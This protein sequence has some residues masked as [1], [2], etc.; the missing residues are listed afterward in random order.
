[1]YIFK[2]MNRIMGRA[3]AE[4]YL[5]RL[6]NNFKFIK[7]TVGKKKIMAAI[8]ADAYG[9]GA[10]EVAKTLQELGV[11]MFGVASIE[12]GIELRLSGIRTKIVILSPVMDEQVEECIEY[13]LIPTISELAFFERLNKKLMHYRKPLL[14]HIEVDTGM[15]RTGFPYDKTIDALKRILSSPYIKIEGIFS[16]FP[17]AD[18]DGA[19]SREQIKKFS[20]LIAQLDSMKIRPKFVHLANSSGIFRYPQSHFNLVRPGISLYGLRSSP[21][22]F[23]NNHFKPVMSL[24]SRIVNI[25]T[26]PRGTPISYGHTYHTNR[27]SRIATLSVGYGDG[28]PRM[29]SNNADVLCYGKRAKIVGTICMDLMMI[30]VTDIPQAKLGDVVTLIGEDGK[31]EIRAEELAQK[32]NTIVYEITS[33]I[34]PRVARVFKNKDKIVCVRNLLGRWQNHIS[35]RYK[36]RKGG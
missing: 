10:I 9:H 26:V 5:D 24:K 31:E 13:N 15:T 19:F 4:I 2:L 27:E 36:Y 29:L 3:W 6:A 21:E 23:Y 22:V 11:D 7:K 1:M 20:Y 17:L 12:E 14:V 8:K 28:Y 35:S 18:S 25:H 30:D 34:G 32:C 33:G 16:H